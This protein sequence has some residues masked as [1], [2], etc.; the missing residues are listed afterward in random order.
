MTRM[1]IQV[2]WGRRFI[3]IFILLF[4]TT[5]HAQQ[6]EVIDGVT[7]DIVNIIVNTPTYDATK[8]PEFAKVK[9]NKLCPLVLTSDDMGTS[10]LTVNWAFFNGYPVFNSNTYLYISKGDN[11]MESPF[12]VME[13]KQQIRSLERISHQPL[14]YSDG[15]GG[16]RRF[17]ATSAIWPNDVNSTNYMK[18]NG[19]DAKTMMRTGWSF[20]QHD[21]ES[22]YTST[23]ETISER[24]K[25]LS[26]LWE[27]NVG[28]GLKV[29]VEPNGNHKYIDAGKLSDEICWNI[30]QNGQLPNYPEKKPTYISDWTTGIDWTTFNQKPIETTVR[31]FFQNKEAT[32]ENTINNAD[33]TT[34]IIGGSHGFSAEILTYLKDVVQPSDKFWVTGADEVWEYYHLY[35]NAKITDVSYENGILSFK[36]KVPRY[37][38]SQF[39]ELT[40]NIPG[41]TNGTSHM[42]SDNVITGGGQQN[43]EY[44]TLNLGLDNSIYTYIDELITWYRAHQYNTYVKDDAQYLINRLIPGE[45]QTSFQARL[46]AA[47]TYCTYK[48]LTNIGNHILASG[49]QDEI[50]AVT[51]TFPKYLL[52]GTDLYVAPKNAAEPYYVTTFMPN[53]GT[54]SRTVT[55]TKAEENVIYFCEGEDLEGVSYSPVNTKKINNHNEAE[56]FVYHRSSNAAGGIIHQPVTLVTLQPGKYKL[57]VAALASNSKANSNTTYQFKLGGNTI[58]SFTSGNGDYVKDEIIVKEEQTLTLE[59]ENP[60]VTRWIDYLY[61]QKTGDYDVNSPD[62]TISSPTTAYDVTNSTPITITATATPKVEGATVIRTVIKDE[63]NEIVAEQDGTTCTFIFTPNRL[64]TYQFVA[65]A[66]D[67][68]NRTGISNRLNLSII[69]DLTFTAINN[70]GDIIIQGYYTG[71]TTDMNLT[72]FYPRFMLKGTDLYETEPRTTANQLHYGENLTLNLANNGAKHIIHYEKVAPNI[73]FYQEGE[74]ING[75]TRVTQDYGGSVTA[76]Y[77]ALMLGSAGAAG[78][79]SNVNVAT[80]PTG[81]YKLYAGIGKTS[82]SSVGDVTFTFMLD[83]TEFYQYTANKYP[84]IFDVSSEF[85]V[86]ESESLLSINISNNGPKDWLDYLYIQRLD[87][88]TITISDAGYATFSSKYAL[89]FSTTDITAYTATDNNDRVSI[90]P[91]TNPVPAETGLFLK[92]HPGE[93]ITVHVPLSATIPPEITNNA[94]MPHTEEGI[95]ETGNYV[96]SKDNAGR[97]AFRRL[98]KDTNVPAGRAYLKSGTAN[99]ILLIMPEEPTQFECPIAAPVIPSAVYSLQGIRMSVSPASGILIINGKKHINKK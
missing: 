7:Y 85:E 43:Q 28:I 48:V 93:T 83:G 8:P 1:L 20:A 81:R 35:N 34:F 60:N 4:S 33:G 63:N 70:L 57:T 18:I 50:T 27:D 90:T 41:I 62:V 74:D 51:Y 3:F 99:A 36:V 86:T 66:T 73:I 11:F 38:K 52:N 24:F 58:Y 64:G 37:K 10:E 54:D 95:V 5:I 55:Y 94:L 32:F 47:P 56:Y 67:D 29:M 17:T 71:Q 42:F 46:D 98:T 79:F 53:S 14:T 31:F 61:I 75:A 6:T 91:I 84:A 69:S 89:D 12:N 87:P 22:A 80:L 45:I 92:G 76:E 30:F 65:E 88:V 97:L 16:V 23:A 44:Y 77:Y 26:D 82:K 39:R 19:T 9:Y 15:T 49:A 40:I 72:Y 59:A 78:R 13:W 96:F 2:L 68:D 25:T 21:V